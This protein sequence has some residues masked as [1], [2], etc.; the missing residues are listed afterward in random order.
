MLANN[1]LLQ[2]SA[3]RP[4]RGRLLYIHP[5]VVRRLSHFVTI[6]ITSI[7]PSIQV[8]NL[9]CCIFRESWWWFQPLGTLVNHQCITWLGVSKFRSRVLHHLICPVCVI[10]SQAFFLKGFMTKNN[11]LEID[12]GMIWECVNRPLDVNCSFSS[13]N[14]IISP[15]A[16]KS[17]WK[18]Q[19]FYILFHQ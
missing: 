11:G 3:F 8:R 12:F 6:N 4:Y 16:S 10:F 2:H 1:R 17:W 13:L 5:V 19:K 9:T 14:M 7:K 18:M 15:Y